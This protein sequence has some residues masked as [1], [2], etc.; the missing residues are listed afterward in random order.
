M[1]LLSG[2]RNAARAFEIAKYGMC[3]NIVFKIYEKLPQ[4]KSKK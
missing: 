2:S 3:K 4:S 1:P